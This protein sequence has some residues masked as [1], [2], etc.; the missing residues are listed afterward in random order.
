MP[1]ALGRHVVEA[2]N[3]DGGR[4]L[5]CVPHAGGKRPMERGLPRTSPWSSS[6]QAGGFSRTA[7]QFGIAKAQ[8]KWPTFFTKRFGLQVRQWRDRSAFAEASGFALSFRLR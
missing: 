3:L 1:V 2:F 5:F 7:K 6:G 4:G 8:A